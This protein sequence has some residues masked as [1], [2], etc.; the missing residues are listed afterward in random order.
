[1]LP[2]SSR[3][4][5]GTHLAAALVDDRQRAIAAPPARLIS[6]SRQLP[7]GL[8]TRT[9]V[10]TGYSTR[11]SS[12]LFVASSTQKMPTA[13]SRARRWPAR[14][15]AG[16]RKSFGLR[17]DQ[18]RVERLG[19]PAGCP[20]LVEDS[21]DDLVRAE[22]VAGQG[23]LAL[24]AGELQEVAERVGRRFGADDPAMDPFVTG[25]PAR[26]SAANIGQ[27][28]ELYPSSSTAA[29]GGNS[30]PLPGSS[31][32]ARRTPPNSSTS[33]AGKASNCD[34]SIRVAGAERPAR[35]T[36]P[37]SRHLHQASGEPPV[38]TDAAE[39]LPEEILGQPFAAELLGDH[40]GAIRF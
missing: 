32:M 30:R 28:A 16:P 25:H 23:Q 8:T 11:E 22:E 17:P 7:G 15:R 9:T 20:H 12:R 1:M 36:A 5:G 35:G 31:A 37:G 10:P 13:R 19:N 24:L 38:V 40:A 21:P 18:V 6:S 26:S 2:P 34:S 14:R 4:V 29:S 27:S 3:W 39:E 33:L